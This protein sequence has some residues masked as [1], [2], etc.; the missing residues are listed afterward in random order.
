MR[1][2][3]QMAATARAIRDSGNIAT[4]HNG[5]SRTYWLAGTTP[6]NSRCVADLFDDGWIVRDGA[7]LRLD[8]FP[9]F[10]A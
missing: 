4:I 2:I 9:S 5:P 1:D 10:A 8:A 6:L 3:E 7:T